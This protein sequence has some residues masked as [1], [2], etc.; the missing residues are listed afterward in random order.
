MSLLAILVAGLLLLSGAAAAE[1]IQ[2]STDE[3]GTIR[4]GTVPGAGPEKASEAKAGGEPKD[5]D[6]AAEVKDTPVPLGPEGKGPRNANP[7]A[8]RQ[9]FGQASASRRQSVKEELQLFRPNTANPVPMAPSGQLEPAAPPASVP[10][11]PPAAPP[12]K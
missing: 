5:G 12:Q 7:Q 3:K 10:P 8:R 1:K 6:K 9:Y 4:I 11:V 2:S